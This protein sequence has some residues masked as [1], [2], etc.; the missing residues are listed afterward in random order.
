MRSSDSMGAASRSS[1]TCPGHAGAGATLLVRCRTQATAVLSPR[2][3]LPA[4]YLKILD[5]A[6]A[7][8]EHKKRQRPHAVGC[9]RGSELPQA[10]RRRLSPRRPEAGSTTAGGRSGNSPVH[11]L[12][13]H[14]VCIRQRPLAKHLAD[15]ACDEVAFF[16]ALP[17]SRTAHPAGSPGA[18]HSNHAAQPAAGQGCPAARCH[19]TA[20]DFHVHCAWGRGA[21]G[22]ALREQGGGGGD[23]TGGLHYL[24]LP[25]RVPAWLCKVLTAAC[26]LHATYHKCGMRV[27][28]THPGVTLH[29]PI[30]KATD[31][32]RTCVHGRMV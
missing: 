32:R 13:A 30:C 23:S 27:C 24:H 7:T 9:S 31:L 18:M 12:H 5:L 21:G 16:L 26:G 25:S 14:R 17:D 22:V 3:P 15:H 28:A 29:G 4:Q 8:F 10:G 19:L 6:P 1:V 2:Q 20:R 11:A